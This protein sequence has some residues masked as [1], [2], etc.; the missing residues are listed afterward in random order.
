MEPNMESNLFEL[1][2]DH[3][4]SSFLRETAKWAK[5]L[6]ILGFIGCAMLVLVALFVGS[7]IGAIYQSAGLGNGLG[8]GIGIVVAIFYILFAALYF[9]PCLY[10][11]N[12]AAKMQVA[13]RSNDQDQLGLAFKNLKSCFRFI[14]I[15][16]VITLSLC[17]L[18]FILGVI[19]AT[20]F[21]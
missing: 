9:F 5:F 8:P 6:A 19:G 1:Q 2:V 14:G 20:A 16:T 18:G 15:L 10:L 21:R 11:Y 3:N 12:F 4:S 7:S 13:L 17:V